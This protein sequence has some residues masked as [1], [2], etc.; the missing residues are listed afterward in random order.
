MKEHPGRQAL[1]SGW[2]LGA[3]LNTY[4]RGDP[5]QAQGGRTVPPRPLPHGVKQETS[6]SRCWEGSRLVSLLTLE[7]SHLW[8][9]E[10]LSARQEGRRVRPPVPSGAKAPQSLAQPGTLSWKHQLSPSAPF[11]LRFMLRE[12]LPGQHHI[13]RRCPR[14]L[15]TISPCHKIPIPRQSA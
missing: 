4:S 9:G 8:M 3:S 1:D 14:R 15:Q 11:T 10:G 7:Q 5:A 13:P 6:V 12:M 2:V